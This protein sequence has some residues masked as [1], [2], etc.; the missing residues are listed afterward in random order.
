MDILTLEKKVLQDLA[1]IAGKNTGKVGAFAASELAEYLGKAFSLGIPVLGEGEGENAPLTILLQ[2]VEKDDAIKFDG[3]RIAFSG[4]KITISAVLE[5]GLLNGVYT[6]LFRNGFRWV[7]QGKKYEVV[8]KL[9]LLTV[10][11]GVTNPDLEFRGV[12]IFSLWPENVEEIREILDFL[13]KNRFNLLMTSVSRTQ[14]RKVGWRVEWGQ[15]EKELYPELERRG[16][17]LNVSEHSGRWFFPRTLFKDHP[18]WFALNKDGVRNEMGQNCYSNAEGVEYLKNAYVKYAKEHPEVEILGTWPEDGYGYCQCEK[19]KEPGVV[20]KAVNKIAKAVAEVRPD[21]MVEY[22]S[23]TKETSDVPPEILPEKNIITLIAN[24][25]VAEDWKK[26]SD[27]VGALGVYRLHYHITDNTA[28]RANLPLR[29]DLTAE[30]CKEAVAHNLRGIIPFYIGPDTWFRSCFNLHFLSRFSWESTLSTDQA[31]KELCEGYYGEA[32]SEMA[33]FFRKLEKLPRAYQNTPPPWDIWQN[34]PTLETDYD[35]EN[36]E[37]VKKKM[38]EA[39]NLA[40]ELS[41]KYKKN[42]FVQASTASGERFIWF[43]ETTYDSWHCRAL[44]VKAF[45]A[46]DEATVKKE[47]KEAGKLEQA[48]IEEVNGPDRL[49]YGVGGAWI[50][51]DFFVHWRVQLDQQLYEMRD[52]SNKKPFVDMNPDV[53]LFLPALLAAEEEK[54]KGEGK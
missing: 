52:D 50:D 13:G 2:K 32:A 10:E 15:V 9:S 27:K 31:L 34:W 7:W 33:L 42:A 14:K 3:F 43:Q 39:R 23:Y 46:K 6:L 19:C 5:R 24:M 48:L 45:R 1:V 47:I 8:P 38:A 30:D 25:N 21:L 51:Y 22:L 54:K 37:A 29:I 41:S 4:N 18:E 26:K 49:E 44:A 28:E 20:L 11:E 36:Y 12:C 40:Q 53:E 17:V 35:G 16:M